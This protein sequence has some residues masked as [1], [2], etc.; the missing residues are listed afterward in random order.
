MNDL[1]ILLRMDD[2]ARPYGCGLHPKLGVALEADVRGPS[3]AAAPVPTGPVDAHQL[4]E[5]VIPLAARSASVG[6]KRA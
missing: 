2:M 6:K 5:N 4:P 3:K 1:I